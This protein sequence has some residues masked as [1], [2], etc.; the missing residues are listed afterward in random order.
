V[1]AAP[2]TAATRPRWLAYFAGGNPG[3]G[4]KR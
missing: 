1:P 4:R 2:G 3:G